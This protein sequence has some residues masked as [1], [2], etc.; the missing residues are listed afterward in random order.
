[1]YVVLHW[2]MYRYSGC[3][4][5]MI[6]FSVPTS[7]IIHSTSQLQENLPSEGSQFMNEHLPTSFSLHPRTTI[8]ADILHSLPT[9]LPFSPP[10]QTSCHSGPKDNVVHS[11]SIPGHSCASILLPSSSAPISHPTQFTGISEVHS[12]PLVTEDSVHKYVYSIDVHSIH[13]LQ[14][15]EGLKCFVK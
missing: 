1:M 9:S 5:H 8:S 10:I 7:T 4:L 2:E 12:T 13:N 11:G 14:L 6:F 15:G 3:D